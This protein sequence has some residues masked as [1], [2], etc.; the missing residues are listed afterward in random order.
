MYTTKAEYSIKN[1]S[2]RFIKYRSIIF[3]QQ[4]QPAFEVVTLL[5][6]FIPFGYAYNCLG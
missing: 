6:S 3:Y 4:E 2:R 1:R 5:F